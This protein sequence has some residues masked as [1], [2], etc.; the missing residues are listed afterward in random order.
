MG[1]T[2]GNGKCKR[3]RVPED[4]HP[5]AH[6]WA[7]PPKVSDERDTL[8]R[9]AGLGNTQDPNPQP[10]SPVRANFHMPDKRTS[11]KLQFLSWGT[12]T[13]SSRCGEEVAT[14][15]GAPCWEKVLQPPA[16]SKRTK[17]TL[18]VRVQT[19]AGLKARNL[20][21]GVRGRD[22]DRPSTL[23]APRLG[24]SLWPVPVARG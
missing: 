2:R 24:F 17:A 19:R 1:K 15:A 13:P 7:E 21:S 20:Q 8:T 9:C 23:P 14:N 6:R 3:S 12:E 11:T 22:L 16:P 4:N 18:R 10:H 5:G